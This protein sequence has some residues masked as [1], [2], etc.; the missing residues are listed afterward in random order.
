MVKK[1]LVFLLSFLILSLSNGL[2]PANAYA[3][4]YPLNKPNNKMGI[5]I[6]FDSELTKAAQLVNSSGGDCG[7][8]VIPIQVGDKDLVKW[9]KFMHSA[10]QYHLIPI[11][12]LS[13]EGDAFNTSV[14]RKPTYMDI[15]D[16]ANFLDSLDWPV[17]NRYVI[18]FN[19]VNR[20]DE[21]G[22]AINPAEYADLLSFAV[23]V[24]R[25]RTPDFFVISAGLDNAAPNRPPLY[26]NEYDY[27]RAMNTAVPGIFNQVAGLAS[28][29][30]PNPGFSQPPSNTSTMGIGSFSFERQ[31]AKTLSQKDLPIF[32]TET[33][34]STQ[35]V[36]LDTQLAYYWQAFNTVWNDPNIVT[37]APFLLQGSGGPFQ[38][39]SF[40][41][42]VGNPTK[43][44]SMFQSMPKIKGAPTLTAT[45]LAAETQRFKNNDGPKIDFTKKPQSKD[46]FLP[47]DTV[48]EIYK[49]LVKI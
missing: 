21:W 48:M 37:V 35:A 49:W 36:S 8:V 9:Q 26:M 15:I 2:F 3:T 22:G 4:E 24:F 34:W 1:F 47:M 44:F 5:H 23:A 13:T 19:E 42:P 20:G 45:V 40:L 11:L 29:S 7:Y 27:M 12:R 38:K 41:D 30:Y 32:I 18:V 28:H 39:F 10:K 33:G 6:L 46:R 25:S 31:L 43:L 17:K 14:W 16:F